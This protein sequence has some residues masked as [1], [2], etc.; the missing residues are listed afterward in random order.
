MRIGFGYDVH[1]LMKGF[2]LWIGGIKV[3]SP[4]GAVG[5]S[6]ADV[7]I[8]AICDAMLGSSNLGDIG[9]HF[10]DSN[11]EFKGIDSKILLKKAHDLVRGKGFFIVN[12]DTTVCLQQPKIGP[13][14]PEM[15]K[16]LAST[17]ALDEEKIS[18][19]ATTTEHLGFVGRGEGIAAY[20]VTLIES[21]S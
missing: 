7:L 12:I 10:P 8:H 20:A 15:K 9:H 17:L 11:P 5:H 3:P 18:I 16:I 14:L 6:D 13:F 21:N 4:T 19:K 1:P 2:D